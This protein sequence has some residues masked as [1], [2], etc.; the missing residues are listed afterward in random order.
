M[1]S[2]Q[3]II[4]IIS[5]ISNNNI[6]TA[7]RSICDARPLLQCNEKLMSPVHVDMNM[8]AVDACTVMVVP[9]PGSVIYNVI[10]RRVSQ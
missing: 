8:C 1:A 4:I 3:L 10:W 6:L 7:G 9:G 5:I 2:F